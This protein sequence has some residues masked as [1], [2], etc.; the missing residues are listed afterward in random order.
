MPKVIQYTKGSIAYFEGDQDDRIFILQKG[1]IILTSIDQETGHTSTE[2]VKPG[3]FFGVKSAL[4]HFPREETASIL[5]ESTVVCLSIQ[6][7]EK[8]FSENKQLIMKMLRV[9]SNQLRQIHKKTESILNNKP[10][11]Q[12]TEMYNVA[13][14]FYEEEEYKSCFDVCEKLLKCFPR[15]SHLTEVA[16]LYKQSKLFFEKIGRQTYTEQAE[17]ISYDSHIKQFDLPAF[18][19]FA[20]FY[21]PGD[22]IISEFEPGNTFYLILKGTVQLIKCVN[23]SKKNLDIL[24]PGDFFGEMAILDNSPRSATCMAS[25]NVKC[26]EFSKEN[27]EVLVTGNP[28]IALS[29]LKLFCK[30][31]YDQKRRFRILVIKN[32]SARIADVFLMLNEM[33]QMPYQAARDVKFNVTVQDVAH[34]AG[35][36]LEVTRDE[37]NKLAEKRKLEIFENY[38]IVNNI[39]DLKRIV[40]TRYGTVVTK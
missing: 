32:Y 8:L 6:E 20:K 25:S 35:L 5:A 40:D 10:E 15:T 39:A 26:L 22:V 4:G 1:L 29:L 23:D 17:E 34:W 14:C 3:E 9:F 31:I 7:F 2:Q 30:R 13:K 37:I 19:R 36:S 24:K 27:F 16:Q 33:N 28:Q 21:N 11:A 38:I 12:D 18:E